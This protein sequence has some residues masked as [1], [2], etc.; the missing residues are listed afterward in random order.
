MPV[1]FIYYVVVERRLKFFENIHYIL[2]FVKNKIISYFKIIPRS[3]INYSILF[4]KLF[5]S[6]FYLHPRILRA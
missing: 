3:V 2:C 1:S 6:L 4:E 5:V